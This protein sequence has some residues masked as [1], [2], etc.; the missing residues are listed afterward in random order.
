MLGRPSAEDLIY[1]DVIGNEY[2]Y[3]CTEKV[4]MKTLQTKPPLK[5]KP[6]IKPKR[7]VTGV[8]NSSYSAEEAVCR[9]VFCFMLG[10]P[11]AEDLIYSDVIGNEYSYACTE[12]VKM[13]T[14]QTKPPLKPK[15]FIKPKR[16]VT[17]V[18]NSS[19]SAEEAVCREVFCFMLGH[20]SAED[21]I[22][23]DVIGNEYSYACT[24]NVKMKTLQTKPP[25]KPK[26]FIK[27]KRPVTGVPNSSYSAEEAVCRKVFCFML[28]RPS[29]EDLIYS[30]IIG[31][32]Y[33]YA[34]TEKVKMKTLQTNPPL[35]PKPF[36]KPKRP[37]T[38]VP[39]SSYSAEEAVYREVFCFMLGRPSA[40]DLIYSDVIGNEYSYACTEKVKMKTLQTK[41]P[42][43]PKP[44]I[45]PKRPVTGVPNSSY[46]AE[47][48]VC[49]E[50]EIEEQPVYK[51]LENE[52]MYREL[53]NEEQPVYKELKSEVVYRELENEVQPAYK[54]VEKEAVYK[55]LENDDQ[56]TY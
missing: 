37:V 11:S 20:P 35:K 36:I 28:G 56:S 12:K 30:D 48:A 45:K 6:F 3:A 32:E 27:P 34:C 1:S 22:Y 43:K 31:N 17:G 25:L 5:P 13:K 41:P 33:S 15:P 40:E 9:E 50:V 38:G 18:P 16:P 44:F 55:D 8:P 51:E 19:Y 24:E 53:E 54:V 46:S 49:R 29:A 2:S 42:L 52:N 39:N 10:R 26:P 23:S 21:L 47:E 14:L 4:K 7:P